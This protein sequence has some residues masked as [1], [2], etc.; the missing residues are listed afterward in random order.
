MYITLGEAEQEHFQYTESIVS[1]YVKKEKWQ[2][3]IS[4]VQ[5]LAQLLLR[6]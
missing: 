5:L 3:E 4:N 1:L 6:E 2:L